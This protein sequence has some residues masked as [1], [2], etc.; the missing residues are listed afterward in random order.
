MNALE[1]FSLYQAAAVSG[2]KVILH[3]DYEIR[4]ISGVEV[5]LV[6]F[7]THHNGKPIKHIEHSVDMK[8]FE[9]AQEQGGFYSD[10]DMVLLKPLVELLK[11][12]K[13]VFAYQ[14]KAYKTIC[15]SFFG[16]SANN[17]IITRAR[18]AYLDAYPGKSYHALATFKKLVPTILD[19]NVF[20]LPQR[21][22]FP[23]R[24]KDPTF[25][26]EPYSESDER[27]WGF[28]IHLWMHVINPDCIPLV[29]MKLMRI[30]MLLKMKSL[31]TK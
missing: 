18:K 14:N 10:T 28:G 19:E 22:F 4:D 23:V 13:N 8:R 1:L 26:T 16:C 5:R 24:M 7:P 17:D 27:N 9:V 29:V 2:L 31:K 6:E 30:L 3:T 11:Y 12:D 20:I 25:Y 15:I 21:E